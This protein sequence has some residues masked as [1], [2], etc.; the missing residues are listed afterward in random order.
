[1]NITCDRTAVR[2][3]ESDGQSEIRHA[4]EADGSMDPKGEQNVESFAKRFT[5]LE[6]KYLCSYPWFLRDFPRAV[7]T[8]DF[9]SLQIK[10][11]RSLIDGGI[12]RPGRLREDDSDVCHSSKW[13]D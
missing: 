8:D 11:E 7:E 6:W 4:D 10:A 3:L 12:R 5:H 13:Y 9:S 2:G 1:M